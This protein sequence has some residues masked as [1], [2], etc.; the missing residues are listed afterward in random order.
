MIKKIKIVIFIVL[1]VIS[2][3]QPSIQA[4]AKAD[5]QVTLFSD[6]SKYIAGEPISLNYE[7]LWLGKQDAYIYFNRLAFPELEVLYLNLYSVALQNATTIPIR[8]EP[9]RHEVHGFAPTMRGT[10]ENFVINSPS[11]PLDFL[12]GK[13]SIED[14]GT[15]ISK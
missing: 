10:S 15:S 14:V 7:V 5:I 6:R 2:S 9:G 1:L 11:H 4:G 12:N 8:S 3:A 13:K